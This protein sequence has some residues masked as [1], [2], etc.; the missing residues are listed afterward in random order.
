MERQEIK[1]TAGRFVFEKH[2]NAHVMTDGARIFR[3]RAAFPLPSG[4]AG[5]D[6]IGDWGGQKKPKT[7]DRILSALRAAD[8]SYE[9]VYDAAHGRRYRLA[10][11][12]AFS[13]PAMAQAARRA[14]IAA[15]NEL[16]ATLA[17]EMERG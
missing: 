5:L 1:D 10:V 12:P 9:L 2:G 14:A 7:K 8:R 15:A 4:A 11:W 17:Y 13:D 3:S 16:G 6:K